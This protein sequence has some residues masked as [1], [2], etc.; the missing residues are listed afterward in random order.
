KGKTAG[1]AQ[2]SHRHANFIVNLGGAKAE[3]VRQ[4]MEVARAEV[5]RQFGVDLEPEVRLLGEWQT[6]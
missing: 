2:I 3:E 4:L 1:R 6:S 5:K